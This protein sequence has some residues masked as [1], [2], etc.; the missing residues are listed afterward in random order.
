M[1]DKY[2]HD[3]NIRPHQSS[4]RLCMRPSMS[5]CVMIRAITCLHACVNA[6]AH[7]RPSSSTGPFVLALDALVARRPTVRLPIRKTSL[8][9]DCKILFV[10]TL[11]MRRYLC[12]KELLQKGLEVVAFTNLILRE[13]NSFFGC[14]LLALVSML[15]N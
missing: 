14:P 15:R 8:P 10:S 3:R 6:F 7:I 4:I 12:H 11:K 13:Y 9:T 2:F 1:Y 5:L